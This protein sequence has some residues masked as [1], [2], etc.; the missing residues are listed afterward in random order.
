MSTL[1]SAYL[2]NDKPKEETGRD[3]A[4]L[5]F[6][7]ALLSGLNKEHKSVPSRFFYDKRGSELFEEIT[8]L[9]EYYLTRTET[10]ILERY[11][12]DI[13]RDTPSGSLLVEFG[14]GSSTKTEIL[15]RKLDRLKGYVAV[16]ISPAALNEAAER[17]SKRFPDLP[18]Y[19]VVG[20]FSS[21]MQLP[22]QFRDVPK[23]G[24]F[25]GSTIG[26][27]EPGE[28]VRL[29]SNMRDILGSGSRLILGADLK[30]DPEILQR[31]YDDSQ[32]VTAQF[33]LNLLTRANRELGSNF[34]LRKFEHQAIYNEAEG[35]ME[36]YLVSTTDQTVK[37]LGQE[38]KFA[39]GEKMH[40]EN[41]HKYDI[42]DIEK[43][44]CSAGWAIQNVCTDDERLFSVHV[45]QNTA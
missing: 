19:T 44:C 18:I 10:A 8:E 23:L 31:A 45:L 9:P 39:A 13:R 33:N 3:P 25:P 36:S 32:G 34:D 22:D 12:E 35:R 5:D 43:L 17:L 16:D 11:A 28:A 40:T 2:R 41:S 7:R 6:A 1:K 26:N 4:N 15:L 37:L 30:K 27:L 21:P 29:L 42:E 14:S 20:N 38:I 24:F